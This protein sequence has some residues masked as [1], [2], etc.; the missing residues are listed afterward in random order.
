M[1]N[2]CFSYK[3]TITCMALH[4]FSLFCQSSN[5]ISYIISQLFSTPNNPIGYVNVTHTQNN[6]N[7]N[8]WMNERTNDQASQL[9]KSLNKLPSCTCKQNYYMLLPIPTKK[10]ICILIRL[11]QA[12]SS[13]DVASWEWPEPNITDRSLNANTMGE[14]KSTQIYDA[15]SNTRIGQLSVLSQ[16]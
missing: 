2:F 6:N 7:N 13:P 5:S 10:D 12:R 9:Q 11:L 3:Q 14:S 1:S 16:A 4:C 8:E 15:F